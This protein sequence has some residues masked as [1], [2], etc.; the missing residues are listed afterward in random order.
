M[1]GPYNAA[2]SLSHHEPWEGSQA[3]G[4]A[5]HGLQ[6]VRTRRSTAPI[7]HT[8]RPSSPKKKDP[9]PREACLCTAGLDNVTGVAIA[10][11]GLLA[12]ENPNPSPPAS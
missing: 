2:F 9:I 11:A 1:A 5:H 10:T 6:T 8:F 3:T 7:Q 4:F 12:H